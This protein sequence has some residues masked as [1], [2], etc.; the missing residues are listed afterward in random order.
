VERCV[1]VVAAGQIPRVASQP[2]SSRA[3][4][5]QLADPR[6]RIGAGRKGQCGP[7]VSTTRG[8]V[9]QQHAAPVDR[10]A[11]GFWSRERP[12]G[13]R[14]GH[15]ASRRPQRRARP[16]RDRRRTADRSDRLADIGHQ[17]AAQT[18]TTPGGNQARPRLP[19]QAARTE[20]TPRTRPR[21]W[22]NRA[23]RTTRRGCSTPPRGHARSA[24]TVPMTEDGAKPESLLLDPAGQRK[25]YQLR[26]RGTRHHGR[27]AR[28]RPEAQGVSDQPVRLE[29]GC[30]RRAMQQT[31]PADPRPL[32][33][34]CSGLSR[35]ICSA[36][37]WRRCCERARTA[38][39]ASAAGPST[40]TPCAR[41]AAPAGAET[42]PTP[43]VDWL[44][45]FGG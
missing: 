11:F 14:G 10:D 35:S 32:S 44:I 41:R 20:G 15:G 2:P 12:S 30:P 43:S 17:H 21:R 4:A 5:S 26:K 3:P 9:G 45:D 39:A 22:I 7:M 18:A 31:A 25:A 6:N 13:P 40:R 38:T 36:G 33:G 24:R 27:H 8:P 28:G 34:S 37:S 1:T 23:K 16:P 29:D 42:D 19:P